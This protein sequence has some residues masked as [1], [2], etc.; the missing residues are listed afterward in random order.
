ME[1]GIRSASEEDILQIEDG[2]LPSR[3]K[4]IV[5][6]MSYT[7]EI[8]DGNPNEMWRMKE[9]PRIPWEEHGHGH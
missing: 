5:K 9:L 4:R 3:K 7:V 6:K 8:E 2:E 1:T